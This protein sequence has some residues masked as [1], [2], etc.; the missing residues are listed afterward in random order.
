MHKPSELFSIRKKLFL[1]IAA[2]ASLAIPI[3]LSPANAAPAPAQSGTSEFNLSG[4][5]FDVV[6]IKPAKDP[7]GAW[8]LNDTNDGIRGLNIPLVYLVHHAFGIYEDNRYPRAPN[9]IKSENY[10]IEAKMESSMAEQF[11]KLPRAQRIVAEQHMLQVLLQERFNLKAH[12]D[13]KEF[14]VY[15]LVIAKNGSKLQE[16]KPDPNDPSADMGVWGGGGTRE[17][18]TTMTAHIVPIEQLAR[19]LT[20]IVGR[21]VLD[22]TGL[23]GRYDLTLKYTP[24]YV[25]LRSSTAA[26]S[27]GQPATSASSP[28]GISIF[29]ALQDQ[30]G[31]KL[32]SGKGPVEIIVID[33][34]EHASGN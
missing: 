29:S 25:A 3:A 10:D 32:E 2:L 26:A 16:L 7:S 15:F 9:W 27:E 4:F 20:G 24:E 6:S 14:P 12:R 30:L 13:T 8:G 11:R 21:T 23:A 17:G 19:Q 18:V 22:K 28:S 31:L 34:I 33:H 5:K 1:S